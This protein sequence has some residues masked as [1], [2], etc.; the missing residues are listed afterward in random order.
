[1]VIKRILS[2]IFIL[3]SFNSKGQTRA[4]SIKSLVKLSNDYLNALFNKEDAYLATTYWSENCFDELKTGYNNG[5]IAYADNSDLVRLFSTD[6]KRFLKTV[7]KPIKFYQIDNVL[8]F[9]GDEGYK[10]FGINFNLGK[11]LNVDSSLNSTSLDFISKDN[12]QSWKLNTDHWLG[13]YMYFLYRKN[14][15]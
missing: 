4:D 15:R 8:F 7:K 13:R 11:K 5:R 14:N 1:M 12:G 3:T 2:I 10:Y 6:L 9:T